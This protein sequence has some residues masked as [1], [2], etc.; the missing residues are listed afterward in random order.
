MSQ[1]PQILKIGEAPRVCASVVSA[2]EAFKAN[3][4]CKYTGLFPVA[5][6]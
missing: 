6:I 5:I 1:K 2:R 4:A 3:C